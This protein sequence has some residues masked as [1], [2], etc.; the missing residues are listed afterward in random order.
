MCFTGLTSTQLLPRGHSVID[1]KGRFESSTLESFLYFTDILL[2]LS[3][4]LTNDHIQVSIS[5]SME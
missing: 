4:V 1:D 2:H 5:T 3:V